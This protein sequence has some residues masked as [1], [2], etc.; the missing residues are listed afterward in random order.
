[1]A[2]DD[3][4]RSSLELLAFIK[5]VPMMRSVLRRWSTRTSV[6]LATPVTALQSHRTCWRVY[7]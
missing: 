4:D 7:E 3:A 5:V 2:A 1:M 6:G